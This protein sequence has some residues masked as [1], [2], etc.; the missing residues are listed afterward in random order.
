MEVIKIVGINQNK[1]DYVKFP[2]GK[3]TKFL[4]K[5]KSNLS[6]TWIRLAKIMGVGRSMMYF[7]LNEC[8]KM[9]YTPFNR[10]CKLANL[11]QNKFEF[12]I[13]SLISKGKA[14]I[15]DKITPKL[16]EFIGILLG[17]GHISPFKYQICISLD[18]VLDKR[19]TGEVVKNYFISLFGKE[20]LIYYSKTARN[21]KCFIYSKEVHDFLTTKIGLPNG[22]KKY[23]IN[24]RIPEILF[25][26]KVLLRSTIRGLFDTE[27]GFYQHNKT[28]PRLYIYNTS[29]PLLNSLYSALRQLGYKAI[30]KKSCI[31]ICKK[32]EIRKFFNEIGSNNPQKQLKYQIW[33]KEGKVPNNDRII[34]EL[35]RL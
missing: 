17:D 25:N 1:V 10:L 14:K 13:T 7:Y 4:R 24:N 5:V 18:S 32:K 35:K 21:I 31:K 15:P 23:N 34:E 29:N 8:C 30:M 3:Q 26:D 2:K 16:A 9:P 33:L 11:N 6:L 22:K 28:S 12:E 19:Y 27:G 20:P